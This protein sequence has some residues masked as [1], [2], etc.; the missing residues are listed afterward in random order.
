M[1]AF[2]EIHIGKGKLSYLW[3]SRYPI[4]PW[5]HRLINTP[6]PSTIIDLDELPLV[7]RILFFVSKVWNWW[8]F[9]WLWSAKDYLQIMYSWTFNHLNSPLWRNLRQ[10]Y[11]SW[12]LDGCS[13]KTSNIKISKS[14]YSDFDRK[15]SL[16]EVVHQFSMQLIL[17]FTEIPHLLRHFRYTAMQMNDKFIQ[18]PN[19]S[20]PTYSEQEKMHPFMFD[21]LTHDL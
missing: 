13:C 6:F 8:S 15:L 21:S 1:E 11:S 20:L 2:Q 12:W 9:Q 10:W 5:I 19:K 14:S 16:S 17:V 3:S 18:F 4:L 7:S